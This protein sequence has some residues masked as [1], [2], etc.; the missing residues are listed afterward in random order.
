MNVNFEN[1]SINVEVCI[2]DYVTMATLSHSAAASPVLG[3]RVLIVLLVVAVAL[4]FGGQR[5]VGH[6]GVIA[7]RLDAN[8]LAFVFLVG[9]LVFHLQQDKKWVIFFLWIIIYGFKCKSSHFLSNILVKIY[10]TSVRLVN[11][12]MLQTHI[13]GEVSFSFSGEYGEGVQTHFETL[14]PLLLPVALVH[15]LQEEVQPSPFA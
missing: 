8:H 6:L 5:G 9:F 11:T 14:L 1:R 10:H 13:T 15:F 7:D 3:L 2:Y 12:Q 4:Q